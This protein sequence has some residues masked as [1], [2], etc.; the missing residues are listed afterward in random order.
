M[1]KGVEII[2]GLQFVKFPPVL[3]SGAVGFPSCM[4]FVCMLT[5]PRVCLSLDGCKGKESHSWDRECVRSRKCSRALFVLFTCLDGATTP[6]TLI[7]QM[8]L[9]FIP[10]LTLAPFYCPFLRE[11][12]FSLTSS[13]FYF[14]LF[15]P[16][17]YG[18]VSV[19]DIIWGGVKL[20]V[21]SLWALI[22]L[23]SG[24]NSKNSYCQLSK[25]ITNGPSCCYILMCISCIVR[26]SLDLK[27]AGATT[28]RS[29]QILGW[30]QRYHKNALHVSIF[31]PSLVGCIVFL[32]GSTVD[33]LVQNASETTA[34]Q[35]EIT[36]IL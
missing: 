31:C 10:C 15:S 19:S 36:R 11:W 4:L 27:I 28:S 23:G 35:S 25:R 22:Y 16:C 33:P 1:F 14:I 8:L 32:R 13:H 9:S 24:A 6:P 12:L 17:G 34:E 3:T 30:V 26:L 18:R 7:V 29:R 2:T 20:E 21:L 5:V